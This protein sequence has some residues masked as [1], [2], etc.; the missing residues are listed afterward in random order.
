LIIKPTLVL[1]FG[2]PRKKSLHLGNGS[3][4]KEP[5]TADLDPTTNDELHLRIWEKLKDKI[6]TQINK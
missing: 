5:P 2:M 4:S 3:S 1:A 6:E